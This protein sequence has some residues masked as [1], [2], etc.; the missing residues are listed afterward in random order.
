MP[1]KI[2]RV[3][4]LYFLSMVLFFCAVLQARQA[5]TRNADSITKYLNE[6]KELSVTKN[7]DESTEQGARRWKE[8]NNKLNIMVDKGWLKY[9]NR[10]LV[11]DFF[12][13]SDIELLW[14]N[15]FHPEIQIIDLNK[16]SR[17]DFIITARNYGNR[18]TGYFFLIYINNGSKLNIALQDSTYIDG[19]IKKTI[20]IPENGFQ[21]IWNDRANSYDILTWNSKCSDNF[22]CNTK[23]VRFVLSKESKYEKK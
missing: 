22:K 9:S 23:K 4:F 13:D 17:S 15:N 21:Y 18:G 3:K 1:V 14:A 7:P 16:D 6:I 8:I 19:E 20:K 12:E 2:Y 10:L 5:E 11:P